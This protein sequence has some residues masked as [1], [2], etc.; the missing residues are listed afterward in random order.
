MRVTWRQL[1]EEP[2]AIVG[3]LKL[4]LESPSPTH[5]H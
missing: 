3:D 5:T 4:A 2:E 1:Q